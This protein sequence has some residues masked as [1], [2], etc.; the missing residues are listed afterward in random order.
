MRELVVRELALWELAL[1]P[2]QR[3]VETAITALSGHEHAAVL[4]ACRSLVAEAGTRLSWAAGD[5]ER[6]AE[7][8][9]ERLSALGRLD[10]EPAP[11]PAADRVSAGEASVAS[12]SPWSAPERA[13]HSAWL[14]LEACGATFEPAAAAARALQL[15]DV[16]SLREPLANAFRAHGAEGDGA[17]RLAARV[18]ALLAH[19]DVSADREAWQRFL[20]DDDARF[21]A[22]WAPGEVPR[23]PPAWSELP[24]RIER[25]TA[26]TD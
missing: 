21:A 4:A 19:P 17:W 15:F 16:L 14:L 10:T 24:A 7:R 5:R 6:A 2:V 22:G 13:A 3:L 8:L 25:A 26:P 20:D 11:R 23:T 9:G 18:R 12:H 1:R